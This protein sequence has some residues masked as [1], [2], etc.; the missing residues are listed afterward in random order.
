MDIEIVIF[1][2]V[3]MVIILLPV[4]VTGIEVFFKTKDT[5][6]KIKGRKIEVSELCIVGMKDILCF[7]SFPLAFVIKVILVVSLVADFL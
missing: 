7:M 6:T 1:L 5:I 2:K 4:T 3:I